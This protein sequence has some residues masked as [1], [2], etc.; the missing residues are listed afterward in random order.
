M[1]RKPSIALAAAAVIIGLLTAVYA[2]SETKM[3]MPAPTYAPYQAKDFSKILGMKGLSDT[4]VSNHFKLYQGYVKNTNLLLEKL[5]A[6]A[7]G[8]ASPEYAELKRRLGFEFNGMRLHELYFGNLGGDG[9]PTE[10]THLAMMIKASFGSFESW[11]KDF[12][13]VGGMRGVGWAVLYTDPTNMRLINVWIDQHH[14]NHLAG[15]TPILVMDVWEHAYMTD[16]QLDRKAYMEA[17]M[18]NIDWKAVEARCAM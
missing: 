2:Q 9:K 12:L 6:M 7:P 18:N 8:P 4:M 14:V 10:G 16:Y 13:A 5:T 1:S 17:F 11:K 15:A 3:T